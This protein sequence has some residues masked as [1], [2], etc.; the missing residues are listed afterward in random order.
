LG[1]YIFGRLRKQEFMFASM[2][3]ENLILEALR[4]LSMPVQ[5]LAAC[6]PDDDEQIS[7]SRMAHG[8]SGMKRFTNEQAARLLGLV[9][10]LRALQEEHAPLPLRWCQPEL[11][12]QVLRQRR[13]QGSQQ[14]Q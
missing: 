7:H 6:Q 3:A 10:E 12:K 13:E 9:R 11:Y 14:D 2:S 4:D 1:R 8:L 5:F